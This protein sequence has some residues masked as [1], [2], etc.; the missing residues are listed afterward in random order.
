MSAFT[1]IATDGVQTQ[2]KTGTNL[3]SLI[4]QSLEVE[5]VYGAE[6]WIENDA[7][8]IVWPADIATQESFDLV[9]GG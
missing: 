1:A 8:S 6:V 7:G 3:R 4:E 2:T 5:E 9:M